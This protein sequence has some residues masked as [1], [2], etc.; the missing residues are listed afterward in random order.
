MQPRSGV[1]KRPEVVDDLAGH[2][3]AGQ[4]RRHPG[5]VA[6]DRLG[7][8]PANRLFDR[9]CLAVAE[10]CIA[11]RNSRLGPEL[12]QRLARTLKPGSGPAR[13]DPGAG[14]E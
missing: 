9:D 10:E 12:G 2:P 13:P 4:E 11:R 7:G 14:P 8:D 1:D 5:R 6:G 3:L